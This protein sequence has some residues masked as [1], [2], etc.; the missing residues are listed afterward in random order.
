MLCV[1]CEYL[2]VFIRRVEGTLLSLP[3]VSPF[4]LLHCVKTVRAC[5]PTE[6]FG[7]DPTALQ[8][9][10]GPVVVLQSVHQLQDGADAADGG[11]DGGGA[12][13]LR[14]QVRV[15]GQ[16]DLCAHATSSLS[17][18]A[19]KTLAKVHNSPDARWGETN[20]LCVFMVFKQKPVLLW[21]DSHKGMKRKFPP[22]KA[23]FV[24]PALCYF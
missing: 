20:N 19:H 4:L 10:D 3:I 23:P 6:T 17:K 11:V 13:E 24:F 16:L 5:R 12:D 21:K 7:A 22:V 15:E 14:R 8:R 1:T 2:A 9:V 18:Q